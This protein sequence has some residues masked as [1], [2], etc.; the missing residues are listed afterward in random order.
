VIVEHW[1]NS[2]DRGIPKYSEDKTVPMLF[3]V[4]VSVHHTLI[5]IKKTNLMQ[6]SS[7][8]CSQPVYCAAVYRE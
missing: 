7:I 5:Y 4:W 3:Y 1:Y 8:V 2:S 6:S